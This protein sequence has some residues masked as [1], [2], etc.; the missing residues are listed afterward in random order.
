MAT[1]RVLENFRFRVDDG[2]E[3]GASWLADAHTNITPT[4]G[5]GNYKLRIRL[6]VT[7]TGT[8]AA[9]HTQYLYAAKNGGSYAACNATRTDGIAI[10]ASS[11]FADGDATTQQVASGTYVAG[12]MDEVNGRCA[13]TASMAQNTHT[14]HEY[15]LQLTFSQLTDGDYFDLRAYQTTAAI[16]T[17]TYTPRITVTKNTPPTTALNTPTDTATGQSLTPTLNFT[18]TDPNGDTVEYEVQ[19]DTVNTFDSQ[20]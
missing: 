13:A 2:D 17:Y 10:I 14:E 4:V 8:T 3:D 16:N 12:S 6:C 18:G 9:T 5:A 11:N 19:V 7:Q 20:T 15:M 1:T